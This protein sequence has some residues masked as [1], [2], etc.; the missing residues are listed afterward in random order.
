MGSTTLERGDDTELLGHMMA[1]GEIL[2][3]QLAGRSIRT[4][5]RKLA[6]AVLISGL[7]EIRNHVGVPQ[8]RRVVD[9][10][11]AWVFSDDTVWPLS[12]LRLCQ[13]FELSPSAIRRVVREW[14]DA[15][16]SPTKRRFSA[17]LDAA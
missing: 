4:P 6:A 7:L 3:T 1:A 8:Y 15:G 12:F 14:V 11:L 5:E 17:Y 13:L 2:P 9:D 10:D 16:A